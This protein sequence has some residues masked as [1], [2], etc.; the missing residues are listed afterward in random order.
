MEEGIAGLGEGGVGDLDGLV[1]ARGEE[2]LGVAN[3][4]DGAD[5]LR[6]SLD[7]RLHSSVGEIPDLHLQVRTGGGEGE[8]VGVPRHI[9]DVVGMALESLLFGQ[10]LGLEQLYKL[11][12]RGTRE[13]RTVRGEGKGGEGVPVSL[14]IRE[15]AGPARRFPKGNASAARGHPGAGEESRSVGRKGE[16]G[17]AIDERIGGPAVAEGLHKKPIATR[18]APDEPLFVF[19][20]GDEAVS[21]GGEKRDLAPGLEVLEPTRHRGRPG[22]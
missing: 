5:L 7:S 15:D 22:P 16:G 19:R 17:D 8:I 13:T 1:A 10:G 3:V 4:D 12:G 2:A 21:G 20:G 18:Q 6:V 14:V 9:E 11:V